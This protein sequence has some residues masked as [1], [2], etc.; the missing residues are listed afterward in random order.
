MTKINLN[1]FPYFD[2]FVDVKDFHQI[3]FKPEFAVQAREMTQ[4]QSILRNQIALFGN[5]IFKQGSL[6][7]PGNSFSE[8][9]VSYLKVASTYSG[10]SIDPMLFE[11]KIIVGDTSGVKAFVKKVVPAT[12]IDPITFYISYIAGGITGDVPNGK[13]LFDSNETFRIE[14]MPAVVAMSTNSATGNGSMAFVNKGVYYINGSF[15]RVGS[16]SVILSKYTTTPSCHVLLKI[17]ESIVDSSMDETLLDPAQGTYNFSAPGA[18]R[19]KI[20]LELVTL[21]LGDSITSDYVEL[22]RFENGEL[23]EHFNSPKYSELEK[24][25]ADRTY[26]ESGDY[27]VRGFDVGVREHLKVGVNGGLSLDGDTNK[28]VYEL[29]PGKAYVRGLAVENLA[30]K[31]LVVD[32]ARTSTHVI[33]SSNTIKPS[34]G[35]YLMIAAPQG[36]LNIQSREA[37]Q[38]WDISTISGGN[39]IGSAKVVGMDYLTGDGSTAPIYMLYVT[40]LV[41]N[42]G[43]S[44]DSIGS[45]RLASGSFYAK[46]VTA[47]DAPTTSGAFLYNEV[48]SYGG[49]TRLATVSFYDTSSGVL[50]A[51]KH[52]ATATPKAGDTITS[53]SCTTVAKTKTMVGKTGAGS[54]VLPLPTNATKALKNSSNSYDFEY[55]HW[56]VLTIAAAGT[57]TS[58]GSG[59]LVPIEAGTFIALT[60][61]GVD[62]R[63]NYTIGGGGTTITRSSGAPAGGVT[64]YCQVQRNNASPRTK[65]ITSHTGTF[66]YNAA[67]AIPCPLSHADVYQIDSIVVG[68]IDV[69]NRY[70]LKDGQTD[71]SYEISSLKLKNGFALPTGTLSV[72]YK[73]F[74]H[75]VGDFF[76]VDSYPVGITNAMI[77][78]YRSVSDGSV[79]QL[80]D[81]ID[82]RKTVGI[83]SNAVVPDTFITTSVQHYVPRFDVVCIDK[84]GAFSVI[85][86]MPSMTPK[87]P[88]IPTSLYAIQQFYVPAYTYAL[89]DVVSKRLAIQR[90]TMAGVAAIE[91]R[92][93]N[94]E[95]FSMLSA[96]E[97]QLTNT[98]FIDAATGLDRFRTGYLV[99]SMEDPFRI[100]NVAVDGFTASINKNFGITAK[101]EEDVI[102]FSM[103]SDGVRLVTERTIVDPSLPIPINDGNKW[104]ANAAGSQVGPPFYVADLLPG[105]GL[106]TQSSPLYIGA[107]VFNTNGFVTLP[108]YDKPFISVGVSSKITNINPFNIVAWNGRLT[109]FPSADIWV[110]VFNRPEI[111]NNITNTV[112]VEGSGGG[113]G[114]NLMVTPTAPS[115]WPTV[116]PP[117]QAT[118][119]TP[120]PAPAPT[121]V[122][123]PVVVGPTQPQHSL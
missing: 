41:I 78:S 30:T 44:Y 46:V 109:L 93:T 55:T 71:Y 94:I 35:Q 13:L 29:S 4:L 27:V 9:S 114:G 69:T 43:A 57:T 62:P 51:H 65:T 106:I 11:G 6:V 15:V 45:I 91:N 1:T 107:S 42:S 31:R 16:Q 34:W 104:P 73:Y 113:G 72:T 18:D 99:E 81:S 24:S 33:Q 119:P 103:K 5:H 28:I 17:N 101:M 37:I 98:P 25:L 14:D 7:I 40:D 115:I 12:T 64:I 92:L 120:N 85:S 50:Y 39:L 38:L 105:N 53:T 59:T 21:P 3:L 118:W 95:Q 58:I 88:S 52:S 56:Q 70:I 112:F 96:V 82:F 23:L 22:M 32:K 116:T 117:A 83:V 63:A 48:I 121:F 67:N 66:T 36:T 54:L 74:S 77:P 47:Y 49:T 89:T 111:I 97:S 19:L 122:E 108:Y 75:S 80:R 110:D 86:G 84:Q 26:D 102:N 60:T 10:V 100:A 20:T 61:S 8:M 79:V 76:S 90:Y 2:D 123:N 68:G 87:R